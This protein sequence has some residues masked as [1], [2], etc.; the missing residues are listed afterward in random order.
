[1][2]GIAPDTYFTSA[3][4]GQPT[5]AATKTP[6]AHHGV[7]TVNAKHTCCSSWR[8]DRDRKLQPKATVKA[9]STANCNQKQCNRPVQPTQT[10]PK[11]VQPARTATKLQTKLLLAF[12]R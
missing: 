7:S 8:F 9:I 6:A 2:T 12:Q 11:A 3:K 4:A 5:Q 10:A 1:M